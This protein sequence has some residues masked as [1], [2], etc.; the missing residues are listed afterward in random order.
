MEQDAPL[1]PTTPRREEGDPREESGS[2]WALWRRVKSAISNEHPAITVSAPSAAPALDH[3]RA[4]ELLLA[5][6][7]TLLPPEEANA[8]SAH[9]IACDS[10]YRFAQDLA[11]GQR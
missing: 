2:R 1:G 8:L 10:C 4:R 11:A 6:R 7:D 9:L 3:G 5:Q